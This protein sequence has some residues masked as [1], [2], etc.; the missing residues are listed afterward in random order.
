MK[1][2]LFLLLSL[3]AFSQNTPQ[4]PSESY[5]IEYASPTSGA[6]KALCG[7]QKDGS[8]VKHGEEFIYNTN[9]EVIKKITYNHG[10]EGEAPA[11]KV[12]NLPGTEEASRKFIDSVVGKKILS[13]DEKLLTSIHD[14]IEILTLK[15]GYGQKNSFKVNGCDNRPM[16][17]VKGALLNMPIK[18]SYSFKDNC[19]VTGSF[20]AKFNTGFSMNFTLRNLDDLNS[21]SLKVIMS[22]NKQE[23]GLRYKFVIVEGFIS[24]PSRQAQ[25]TA[26]YQVD[27]NPMTGD[28]QKGTQSGKINLTKVNDKEVNLSQNI[29][30]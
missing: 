16:D 12:F 1:Y 10:K 17:W 9:G 15:K 29:E 27:I 21:T 5:L 11:F 26:E 30:F 14:L 7:Y 3:S 18:K 28:A 13:P 24:S 20:E 23:T 25:F 6:K 19:D 22:L 2:L 8:T 4:C